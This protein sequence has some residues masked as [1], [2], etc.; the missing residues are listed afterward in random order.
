MRPLFIG[1]L[2]FLIWSTL[3]T[4]YY[5][6]RINHYCGG[7][8]VSQE[9]PSEE[10]QT[11]PDTASVAETE[12]EEE[13]MPPLPETLIIHFAFDRSDFKS[14]EEI[15]EFLSE[16][17]SYI[18]KV[19]DSM[20][21]ITGYTDAVGTESYNLALGISRAESIKSYFVRQGVPAEKIMTHSLGESTPVA[22]NT[23]PQ[24]R[25]ENRRSE[26]TVKNQ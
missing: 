5:V 20:I 10:P 12:A 15:T 21:D 3:A 25:A 22:D 8:E 7:P 17:T 24:G 9:V 11:E 14:S 6:C 26:I 1:I 13:L 4:W 2:L 16:F 23:T 19:P 18:E